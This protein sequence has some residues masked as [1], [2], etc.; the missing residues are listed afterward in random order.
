[1]S[2][3][4]IFQIPDRTLSIS[5]FTAQ[6][7]ETQERQMNLK[8]RL[9]SISYKDC[10]LEHMRL[11]IEELEVQ[12]QLQQLHKSFLD[13]CKDEDGITLTD[14]EK[15][16]QV[17][18]KR[19]N[20][21]GDDLWK[22]MQTLKKLEEDLELIPVLGPDSKGAHVSTLLSL[23]KDPSPKGKR[24]KTEQANMRQATIKMY[25]VKE[26]PLPDDPLEEMLWCVISGDRYE[27]PDM[28]TGHLV[29]PRLRPSV[30]DYL[31]GEG[32]GARLH[33]PD[34]YL[35]M[36]RSV[37]RHFDK[38]DFVLM[39]KDPAEKP[40]KTW[41]VQMTNLTADNATMGLK[42]LKDLQGKEVQFRNLN[43]P[44]VRFLYF[45]FI[46]TLL[47]NKWER[48]AGWERYLTDLPMER[49][50]ATLGPHLRSSML[51]ALVKTASDYDEDFEV[52]VQL[53]SE[54]TELFAE[55]HT[56]CQAEEEELARRVLEAQDTQADTEDS[57]DSDSGCS[58]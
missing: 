46:I 21:I 14:Y 27:G 31:F 56:L 48:H 35:M 8:R 55:K 47:K 10:P 50:F 57:W 5:A 1:M 23:Y 30:V 49:P 43:R 52:A 11:R 38:G 20:S 39:P 28:E 51:L 2:A 34:N 4:M 25:S 54:G 19:I 58:D 33:S 45:H 29:P 53:G 13:R 41:V 22:Y 26:D 36:H 3:S 37:K 44:A 6:Q 15:E 18:N 12:R 9:S 17:T 32:A 24:S 16:V 42:K 7:L 40:L